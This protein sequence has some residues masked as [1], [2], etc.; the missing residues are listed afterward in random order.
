MRLEGL[1]KMK[2]KNDLFNTGTLLISDRFSSYFVDGHR[3][4]LIA[5]K[6]V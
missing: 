3:N 4:T 2:K 1:G 5:L 6:F